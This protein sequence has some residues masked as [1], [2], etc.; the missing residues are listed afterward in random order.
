MSESILISKKETARL[1]GVSLRTVDNLIARRELSVRRVG[2]RV[3]VPRHVL[4][5]FCRRDH[6]TRELDVT[7]PMFPEKTPTTGEP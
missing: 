3:L 1:L 4:E 6:V 5:K 2:R 7:A